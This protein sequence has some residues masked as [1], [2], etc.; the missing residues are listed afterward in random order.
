MIIQES[1]VL[2]RLIIDGTRPTGIEKLYHHR[3]TQTFAPTRSTDYY[4]VK[5]V[6]DG[7]ALCERTITKYP[8]KVPCSIKI[9]TMV[10]CKW[11]AGVKTLTVTASSSNPDASFAWKQGC[12][13]GAVFTKN[14][15][16]S[17]NNQIE[18]TVTDQNTNC[19]RTITLDLD[20]D[21]HS[22]SIG[23]T[24][25]VVLGILAAIVLFIGRLT[26]PNENP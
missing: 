2:Q 1:K 15:P 13:N 23:G 19:S 6:K 4:R 25:G 26:R 17:A 22:P 16:I 24:I 11:W 8:I 18:L 20:C 7:N 10:L 5:S 3:K 14:Y 9:D 21:A 12:Q